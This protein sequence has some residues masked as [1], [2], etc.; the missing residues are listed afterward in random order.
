MDTQSI[1]TYIATNN[2]DEVMSLLRSVGAPKPK[3]HD[4]MIRRLHQASEKYPDTVFAS[5]AKIETPYYQ[6]IM[7]Q[8]KD[9][10]EQLSSCDGGCSGCD[11]KK[12]NA[13]DEAKQLAPAPVVVEK[14]ITKEA[15][16]KAPTFINEHPVASAV[17]GTLL[18]LATV[19]YI[20][21]TVQK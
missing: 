15:V 17:I 7:S 19:V 16:A 18:G 4:E 8:I 2:P 12:S 6:L 20:I 9:K 3:N 5:L 10:E 1:E 21:K 13:V 11:G 14:I